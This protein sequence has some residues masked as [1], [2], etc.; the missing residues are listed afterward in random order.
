MRIDQPFL[1]QA[2]MRGSQKMAAPGIVVADD[3]L[4]N[5]LLSALAT[6]SASCSFDHVRIADSQDGCMSASE[7]SRTPRNERLFE[8]LHA[9]VVDRQRTPNLWALR[10]GLGHPATR[11]LISRWFG[12]PLA[13]DPNA[14]TIHKMTAG[15]ALALHSDHTNQRV[16]A[17]VVYLSDT[18]LRGGDLVFR[19]FDGAPILHVAPR[20]GRMV[21]FDVTAPMRHEVTPLEEGS[22]PRLSVGA[23]FRSQ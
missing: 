14:F 4:G 17:F 18:F 10:A 21:I 23:W 8:F 7:W 9:Q 12:V 5:G 19:S 15:H 13:Y 1:A 16:A 3:R 22:P 11:A 2:L 20:F 6:E